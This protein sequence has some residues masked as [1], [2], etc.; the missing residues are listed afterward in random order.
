MKTILVCGGIGSGKSVVCSIVE[1]LGYSVYNCDAE[2][3]RLMTYSA[4]LRHRLVEAFGDDVVHD[5]GIDRAALA[6][7]VFNDTNKLNLLNSIVHGDVRDHLRH[8]LDSKAATDSAVFVETA[9]PRTSHIDLMVD[10]A[11]EVC[12]P[13]DVKIERLTK[14]RGLSEAEYLRRAATQGNES[15]RCIV[16]RIINDGRE[17]LLNQVL[18]LLR[19]I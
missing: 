14:L 6:G 18:E 8:W 4:A 10:E 3:G 19:H 9:I 17:S 5:E 12:A 1:H 11:W 15:P 2:A 13:E 16:H 7:I